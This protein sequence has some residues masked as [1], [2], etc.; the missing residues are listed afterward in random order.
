M[1]I[2]HDNALNSVYKKK[3]GFSLFSKWKMKHCR[4]LLFYV[5]K[6][7]KFHTFQFPKKKKYKKILIATVYIDLQAKYFLLRYSNFTWLHV[8]IHFRYYKYNTFVTLTT[9][10]VYN[11]PFMLFKN[12]PSQCNILK[13]VKSHMDDEV[14]AW[15]PSAH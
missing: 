11:T 15:D 12:V 3:K 13:Y 7:P 4:E 8:Y 9:R 5:V 2:M 14:C 6:S 10:V 1:K